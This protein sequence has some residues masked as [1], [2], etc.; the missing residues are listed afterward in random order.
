[1][2]AVR[3]LRIYELH[4]MLAASAEVLGMIDLLEDIG[5]D[6]KGEND[7]DSSAALGITNHIGIGKV[8]HLR[9]QTRWV[10]EVR[11]TGRLA[12]RKVLGTLNPA[13]ILTKYV[14]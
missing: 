4:A 1:M 6:A 3:F 7:A 5:I 10:Q 12:Y 2:A 13:N 11:S 14:P 9:V 8:R